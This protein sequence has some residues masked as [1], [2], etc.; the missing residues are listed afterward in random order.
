MI[1]NP[2][3]NPKVHV[4]MLVSLLAL[5]VL[6]VLSLW[7]TIIR[8][9][10]QKYIF[11]DITTVLL[12]TVYFAVLIVFIPLFF[13]VM[14]RLRQVF[15]AVYIQ[16][17]TKTSVVFAFLMLILLARYLTY[18]SIEIIALNWVDAGNLRTYIPFYLSELFV[19]IAYICFLVRVY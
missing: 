11:E 6:E 2:F 3:F 10:K 12:M 17:R 14:R 4:T 15:P 9:N 18:C 5:L 7:A 13:T 8:I 16:V 1:N 19:S